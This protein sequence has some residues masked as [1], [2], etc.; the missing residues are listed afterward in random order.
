MGRARRCPTR[1]LDAALTPR[2]L[3]TMGRVIYLED[4]DIVHMKGGEYTV[5][6][7]NDVDSP[8]VEVRLRTRARELGGAATRAAA[9]AGRA[10]PLVPAC[11][12]AHPLALPAPPPPLLCFALADDPPLPHEVLCARGAG[13]LYDAPRAPGGA[14]RPHRGERARV[15]CVCGVCAH[16]RLTAFPACTPHPH[17]LPSPPPHSPTR[18]PTPHTPPRPSAARVASC[19]W[20]AALP[21]TLPWPAARPWRS[22]LRSRWCWSWPPTCWTAAAP[23]SATTPACLSPRCVLGVAVCGGGG[24]CVRAR[25]VVGLL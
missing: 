25:G 9:A 8:S 16:A 20:R 13:P 7:W 5:Y 12:P 18:P 4:N 17:C 21:T 6:N 23:S 14:G 2:P 11:L 24:V 22:L 19:L 10:S 3:L 15:W 1:P